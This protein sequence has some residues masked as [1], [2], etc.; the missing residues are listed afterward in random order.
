MSHPG[1]ADTGLISGSSYARQ[2]VMELSVLTNP[3]V[4]D[5]IAS[6]N[7]ELISFGDL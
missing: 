2:R 1:Y 5:Y 3:D 4:K 7:I 6:A